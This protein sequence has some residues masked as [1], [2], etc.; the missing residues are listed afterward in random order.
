MPS[1][2]GKIIKAVK[3]AAD[4]H[5]TQMRK[6][7]VTPYINHP[8]GVAS[9]L[10]DAGIDD[11]ATIQAAILHDTIEDTKTT[12]EELEKEFGKEVSDLVME[13]TDDK[14]K[15][16]E[17]RKQYQVDHAPNLSRKAKKVKL[18]DKIANVMD[19]INIPP[20]GWSAKR[21]TE[22][23]DWAEKV[24]NGLRGT[25]ES[26]EKMF[27]ETLKEGRKKLQGTNN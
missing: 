27:D 17:A 25:D 9:L 20:I 21:R 8:V 4:K 10:T 15:S 1:D 13:L 14:T 3:F 19:I 24:V 16:S 2:T 26:L 11:T 7:G 5:R 18:T 12:R 6:N 22:Y 23:L